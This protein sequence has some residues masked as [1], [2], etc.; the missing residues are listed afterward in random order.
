MGAVGATTSQP[1][2]SVAGVS[3]VVIEVDELVVMESVE[4][5]AVASVVASVVSSVVTVLPGA[6][7]HWQPWMIWLAVKPGTGD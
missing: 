3:L 5:V 1:A 4:E 7:K 6:R 2:A